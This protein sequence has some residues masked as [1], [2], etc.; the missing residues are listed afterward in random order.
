M[1][2]NVEN[3]SISDKQPIV[4]RTIVSNWRNGETDA[5]KQDGNNGKR[6][7]DSPENNETDTNADLPCVS[8][9]YLQRSGCRRA[10]EKSYLGK[11]ITKKRLFW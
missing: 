9:V 1:S 3:A 10:S 5:T 2:E 4:V 11:L 6:T 8:T 7:A